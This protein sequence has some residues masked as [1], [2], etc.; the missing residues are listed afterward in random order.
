MS[1]Y[2]PESYRNWRITTGAR[3]IL[4]RRYA[5]PIHKANPESVRRASGFL[6]WLPDDE[7]G[8]ALEMADKLEEERKEDES[9]F[10][11]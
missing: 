8:A 5:D 3:W 7:L 11:N 2:S 4:A 1:E 10:E 6:S 9:E